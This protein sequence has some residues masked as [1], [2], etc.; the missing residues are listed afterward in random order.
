MGKTKIVLAEDDE[1]LS[2]VIIEELEEAGFEMKHAIDGE[3]AVEMTRRERP[4]L[5][6]LDIVM[7]KKDGFQVLT[8]IKASPE[9][10]DIPV[11]IMTMLGSDD[12]VKKGI[13][14]G[15]ADY[16]VKS[17]H[18]VAEIVEKVKGFFS[19]EQHPTTSPLE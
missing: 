15:A 5:L 16:I 12:D 8:E 9:T 11:I 13:K 1:I 4:G 6:L 2:S 19:Q 3:E 10:T 17:Q 18:A 7:P 14:L